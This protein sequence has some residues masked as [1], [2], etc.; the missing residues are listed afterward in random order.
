MPGKHAILSP[1]G[2][3]ALMLCP[4]KPA[5]EMGLP[6]ES[7]E[8][9]DHGTAAHFLGSE[10]LTHGL[11]AVYYAGRKI[12]VSEDFTGWA[13]AD[14]PA[15]GRTFK[16]DDEMVEAI[17]VY[18]DLVR[19]HAHGKQLFVEQ[20]LP[21]GHITGEEGAEGTG[22]GVVT[23]SSEITVI[24][25]KYGMGVK[26]DADSTE[27]MQLYA[28]GAMYEYDI[29]GDFDEIVMVVHQPRLN[30]VSEWSIRREHLLQFGEEARQA[31]VAA[32]EH[33]NPQRIPGEKQCRFCKAKA[34]CPD[35][36]DVVGD[37]VGGIATVSDF[38]DLAVADTA[39]L[40]AAMSRVELVEHWCKA[41]RAEVERRL[42]NGEHVP[43]FKLV[44]GR[45]GNRSWSDEKEAE[46]KLKSLRLTRDQM[47]DLKLISP[48]TAEKLLKKTAPA[49]W[50]KVND[51]IRRADGKPSVAPVTDKRPE[52]VVSNAQEEHLRIAAD[53]EKED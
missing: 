42:L 51:L 7:S 49:K 36:K 9:A 32:L 14:A 37:T 1:S 46:A 24:D 30:H 28:L 25:L 19:A 6:D 35:L 13:D 33:G 40:A 31:A 4:G 16:V 44:E 11:N 2:F 17:Q 43:G 21:I 52:M 20:A 50:D 29:A 22:D 26:V 3:E 15:L 8:Y 18:L 34:N 41:I 12:F 48:T 23:D 38:A 39:P 45:K 10:C 5:M 47:Y 27:Q 53:C